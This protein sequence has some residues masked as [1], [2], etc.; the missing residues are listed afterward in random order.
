MRPY[1]SAALPAQNTAGK[2]LIPSETIV[3]TMR[4]KYTVHGSLRLLICDPSINH[5]AYLPLSVTAATIRP[6]R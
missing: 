4:K 2:K 1:T 6:V 3:K 5:I